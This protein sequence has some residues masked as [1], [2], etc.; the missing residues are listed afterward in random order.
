MVDD[1]AR[2]RALEKIRTFGLKL[3]A[4]WK[5]DREDANSR[6]SD[7]GVKDASEP[8]TSNRRRRS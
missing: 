5:F 6:G 4:D 1:S 7:D 8:P 3:P 2:L